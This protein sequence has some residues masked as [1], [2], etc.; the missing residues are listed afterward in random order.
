VRIAASQER[1]QLLP[2]YFV[3]IHLYPLLSENISPL[4]REAQGP[5]HKAVLKAACLLAAA[6]ANVFLILTA[7][8]QKRLDRS[9]TT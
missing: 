9:I 5:R 7:G 6:F 2:H 4:F 1:K 3:G 8:A